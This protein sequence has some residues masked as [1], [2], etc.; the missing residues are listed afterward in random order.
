[1]LLASRK[2][3]VP[4]ILTFS[5]MSA[6]IAGFLQQSVS[7]IEDRLAAE[8]GVEWQE[9][10]DRVQAR[11]AA[12]TP[13]DAE[14][15]VRSFRDAESYFGDD[16]A[17]VFIVSVAPFVAIA[18][19]LHTVVFFVACMFFLSLSTGALKSGFELAVQLPFF[20]LRMIVFFLWFFV[21]SLLWIPF[22]GPLLTLYLV[23]RLIPAPFLYA[24][25]HT[26]FFPSFQKS[27]VLTRRRWFSIVLALLCLF[28][29]TLAV[30]WFGI[31]VVAVISLLSSKLSYFLWLLL[32]VSTGAIQIF[33]LSTLVRS[34]E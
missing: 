21:R 12:F 16:L 28:F 26:A 25:G 27:M 30:L 32:L 6:V 15:L 22:V 31:V 2:I 23:P 11:L 13:L 5:L 29:L 19:L 8:N 17:F 24:G 20:V 7:R 14:E 4:A 1:M 34:L 9:L 10:H 3:L 33:Y 18:L